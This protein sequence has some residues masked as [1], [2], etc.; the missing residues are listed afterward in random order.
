M[1]IL[2]I[3]G[4]VFKTKEKVNLEE[5]KQNRDKIFELMTINRKKCDDLVNSYLEEE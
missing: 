2:S 4:Y 5:L 1:H 3:L